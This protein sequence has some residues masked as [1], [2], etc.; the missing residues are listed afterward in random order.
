MCP[1]F[2]NFQGVLVL[3]FRVRGLL[4]MEQRGEQRM[5]Q[6][7]CNTALLPFAGRETGR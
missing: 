6:R 3:K 4:G 7:G 2:S 1:H 5:E